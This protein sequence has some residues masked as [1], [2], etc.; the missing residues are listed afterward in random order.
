MILHQYFKQGVYSILWTWKKSG[1]I[2]NDKLCSLK[3]FIFIMVR[4]SS[5]FSVIQMV[6]KIM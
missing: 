1:F 5:G 3:A 6:I 2:I 4:N